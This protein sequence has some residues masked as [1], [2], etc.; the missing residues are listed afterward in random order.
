MRPGLIALAFSLLLPTPVGFAQDR[1]SS[2]RP[3]SEA[4]RTNA[5]ERFDL[6]IAEQRIVERDYHASTSVEIGNAD[7]RG[8]NL[9]VGVAVTA[10][11]I[12]VLLRNV[13]GEVRFRASLDP[14][15]ERIRSHRSVS[16]AR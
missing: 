3:R 13:R 16:P 5:D 11:S 9:R 15:L 8:L 4:R 14:I 2:E 7:E 10:Q 1:D 6:N 12:S